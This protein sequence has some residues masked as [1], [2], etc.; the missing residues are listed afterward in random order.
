LRAAL[1]PSWIR[2]ASKA[3]IPT[4]S[5]ADLGLQAPAP[6]V[7][8]PELINPPKREIMTEIITGNGPREI[9][10]KLVD[11]ILEEKVL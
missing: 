3:D 10:E 5:L 11:K 2:K 9:A 7:T 1:P 6:L 4:W 8:W